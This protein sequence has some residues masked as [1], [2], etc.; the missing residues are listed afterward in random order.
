MAGVEEVRMGR[1][2]LNSEQAPQAPW[3]MDDGW[4][5][6]GWMDGWMDAEMD[7]WKQELCEAY[8]TKHTCAW[9]RDGWRKV[10]RREARLSHESTG[11][12]TGGDQ[13]AGTEQASAPHWE[14]TTTAT[15]PPRDGCLTMHDGRREGAV[16]DVCGRRGDLIEVELKTARARGRS[17]VLRMHTL[18]SAHCAGP[19][20]ANFGLHAPRLLCSALLCS[21]L[22]CAQF[23]AAGRFVPA[24]LVWYHL[25]FSPHGVA[26]VLSRPGRT[27]DWPKP[28]TPAHGDCHSGRRPTRSAVGSVSIG[29]CSFG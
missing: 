2:G 9:K 1:V 8:V 13:E 15:P 7:V 5:V 24:S 20:M 19:D 18:M 27:L 23:P 6:D 17:D 21:A 26:V 16:M 25:S 22:L 29:A 28:P 12:A 10:R 3:W 11:H 14:T 4:M